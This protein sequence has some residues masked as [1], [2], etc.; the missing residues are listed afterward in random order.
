MIFLG[1][2]VFMNFFF[3]NLGKQPVSLISAFDLLSGRVQLGAEPEDAN[4]DPLAIR[5]VRPTVTSTRGQ[6]RAETALA[7]LS[8]PSKFESSSCCKKLQCSLIPEVKRFME[9]DRQSYHGM[10]TIL[11]RYVTLCD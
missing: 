1:A 6:S 3:D 2:K 11:Q 9:Q 7:K 8:Q 5:Y 10:T 4:P